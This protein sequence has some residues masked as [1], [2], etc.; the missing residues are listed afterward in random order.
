MRYCFGIDIGGTKTAVGLYGEDIKLVES[1]SFASE[2][3]LGAESLVKKIGDACR[4]LADNNKIDMGEVGFAGVACPGPLDLKTGK[5][6]YIA[7]MG[8][9]NVPIR[10]MI[11]DEL[12]LP[13]HL[14]NDANCAAI[15]EAM[16]GAGAGFENVTYITVSTGVGGGIVING[17]IL[18]GGASAAAEIGHICTERNGRPCG[19]G[20][21][22]CLEQYA[23]GTAIAEIATERL[24]RT[25]D[26]KTVF[27]LCRGG[28]SVC[29]EV[30]KQAADHLGFALG[31]L[32][33]IADPDIVVLGGS[34]TKDYDVLKPYLEAALECYVQP[35]ATR[36]LNIA[37]SSM[38][39]DQGMLGAA[40]FAAEKEGKE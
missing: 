21:K 31:A 35:V 8:F 30:V 16:R 37:V 6:I 27:A 5:I 1:L 39:G 17:S 20:K 10:D 32:W 9:K 19:C 23:S 40:L 33:Q 38:G 22:G 3:Q 18:D 25:V 12:G 28:D 7:T 15:A 34:V 11:A 4:R 2:P 14:Q 13:V 26:A 24:G 36:K 29:I